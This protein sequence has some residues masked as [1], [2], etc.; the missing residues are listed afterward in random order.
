MGRRMALLMII[1]AATPVLSVH[2]M[3]PSKRLPDFLAALSGECV[4]LWGKLKALAAVW[5]RDSERDQARDLS[6]E[7]EQD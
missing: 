6:L 3:A 2:T 5:R 4:S 1:L 7:Q